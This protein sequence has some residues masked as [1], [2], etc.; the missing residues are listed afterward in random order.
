MQSGSRSKPTTLHVSSAGLPLADSVSIRERG[1]QLA[2][3]SG[4]CTL[5]GNAAS[6][7]PRW[8]RRPAAAA[9]TLLQLLRLPAAMGMLLLAGATQRAQC[10]L[11]LTV[12]WTSVPH[13]VAT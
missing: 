10:D 4:S 11:E 2:C 13:S 3:C 8:R 12:V 5:P 7:L 1:S 9:L 6:L